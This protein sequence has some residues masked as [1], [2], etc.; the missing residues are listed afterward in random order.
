MI[1]EKILP[2]GESK[3]VITDGVPQWEYI[4]YTERCEAGDAALSIIAANFT[5]WLNTEKAVYIDFKV[6]QFYEKQR[7]EYGQ[8]DGN[9]TLWSIGVGI[10]K[11]VKKND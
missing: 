7:N 5:E 6:N 1:S 10:A 3:V 8:F 4:Y 9:E 2:T 11:R